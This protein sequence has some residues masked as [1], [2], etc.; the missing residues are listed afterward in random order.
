MI[1]PCQF[2]VSDGI[3]LHCLNDPIYVAMLQDGV[4][5]F[6]MDAPKYDQCL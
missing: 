4:P 5:T 2:V 1:G 6:T 3:A